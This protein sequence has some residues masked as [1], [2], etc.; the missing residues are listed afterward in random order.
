MIRRKQLL[1]ILEKASFDSVASHNSTEVDENN[2]GLGLGEFERIISK[3][4]INR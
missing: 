4:L 3:S 1:K 2:V